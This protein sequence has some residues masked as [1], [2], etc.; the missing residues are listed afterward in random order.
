[1]DLNMPV[2]NGYEA[3]RMLR[4]KKI[5]A[6]IIILSVNSDEQTKK[7]VLEAGANAYFS[8]S[9]DISELS[10]LIRRLQK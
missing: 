7:T 4:K 1:M 6:I 8:K 2:M 9:S 3:I 10:R 5:K